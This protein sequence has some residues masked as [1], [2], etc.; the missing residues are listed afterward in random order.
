MKPDRQKLNVSGF[1]GDM[2]AEDY[3]KYGHELIDWI[4]DYLSNIE[5]YPVIPK[6]K[7]GDIRKQLPVDPPKEGE[8]MKEILSDI[9]RIILPG[10]THW[11][12]PG[13]LAYF[14]S[15]SSGPGILAELLSAAFNTNGMLWIT[16]P[17]SAELEQHTLQWL[18]QRFLGN[19]L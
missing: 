6:I 16:N 2:P 11:N 18:R 9:D 10:V 17:A 12:H 19:Y 3:R 5:T 7:P 4:A 13:F 14:N 15:T 1:L 8:N